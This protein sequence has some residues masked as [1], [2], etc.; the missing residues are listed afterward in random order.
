[1]QVKTKMAIALAAVV[2][3]LFMITLTEV[4]MHESSS[5]GV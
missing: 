2:F 4:C 3:L 1:M 5:S